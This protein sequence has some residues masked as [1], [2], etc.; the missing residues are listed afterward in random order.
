MKIY[1]NNVQ[2][3]I[4]V[5]KVQEVKKVNRNKTDIKDKIE[6]SKEAIE[7]KNNISDFDNLKEAKISKIK[8]MIESGI[9]N[10]KAEDVA[11]SILKGAIL[12]KR[13]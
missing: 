12:N 11:D 10:V 6:I 3:M 4:S 2:N 7:M 8:S 1:N 13:I 5:Y 9:Y